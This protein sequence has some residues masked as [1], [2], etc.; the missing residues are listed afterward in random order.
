LKNYELLCIVRSSLDIENVEKILENIKDAIAGFGGNVTNIDKIGRR[1]LAFEIGSYRD[2]FYAVYTVELA[3]D[4]VSDL[5][6]Y[7]KLN[8][9]VIRDFITVKPKEKAAV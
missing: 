3:E 8:E 1:K 6:R 7:L 2:G 9:N 5:K 4:K